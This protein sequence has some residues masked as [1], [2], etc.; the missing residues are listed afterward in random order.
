VCVIFQ[1]RLRLPSLVQQRRTV[2]KREQHS[3]ARADTDA[4]WADSS[5]L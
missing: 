3:W 1:L 4:V 2:R 5:K